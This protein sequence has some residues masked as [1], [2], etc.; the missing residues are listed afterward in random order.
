M[1]T[2]WINRAAPLTPN[3]FS[4]YLKNFRDVNSKP[5]L[6]KQKFYKQLTLYS[7]KWFI[8]AEIVLK[9]KRKNFKI[10]EVPVI[11]K[12]RTKGK[13]KIKSSIIKELLADIMK[14]IF[15]SRF[16]KT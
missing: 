9:A 13:S 7:K 3:L 6:I 14:Y 15:Y 11:S 5:K 1:L 12:E 16:K 8:D 10:I 4:L 2:A